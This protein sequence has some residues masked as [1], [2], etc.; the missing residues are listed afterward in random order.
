MK[1]ILIISLFSLWLTAC[2]SGLEGTY[3]DDLG[4]YHFT[5]E[6]Y[7]KVMI[8][9]KGQMQEYEYRVDGDEVLI[10]LSEEDEEVL[11][12]NEDGSLSPKGLKNV[13][14]IKQE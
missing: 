2:G 7:G 9:E 5:F 13:Y 1:K 12:I 14:L 3:T 10:E 6:P 4:I 8:R 11:V